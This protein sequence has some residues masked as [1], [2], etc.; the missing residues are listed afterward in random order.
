MSEERSAWNP[1]SRVKKK[2]FLSFFIKEKK[3]RESLE[4]TQRG[5]RK[6]TSQQAKVQTERRKSGGP[7]LLFFF[8]KWQADPRSAGSSYDSLGSMRAAEK[9]KRNPR[10]LQPQK[11]EKLETEHWIHTKAF[12]PC[13]WLVPSFTW[14]HITW[15]ID[16]CRTDGFFNSLFFYYYF[17][18]IQQ[19]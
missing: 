19:F 2:P 17:G 12:R 6:L 18:S 10:G 13:C 14:S 9:K 16:L 5:L 15:A 4:R 3:R 8:W 1:E 11:Q 7:V